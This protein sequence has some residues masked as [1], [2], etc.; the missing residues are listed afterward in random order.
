[1]GT[2]NYDMTS[3]ASQAY[4]NNMILKGSRYC[5]YSGNINNDQIID[6]DDLVIVD[7]D[8]LNYAG[9]DVLTN[10]NGDGIVD[11]DDMAIV[12]RNAANLILVEWPGL[13]PEMRRNYK[14]K[15]KMILSNSARRI[16]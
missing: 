14:L 7:N 12:D 2:N 8:I 11:I 3:S 4:G 5:V 16:K 15:N 10:L 13:T 9:G 6:A 1:M